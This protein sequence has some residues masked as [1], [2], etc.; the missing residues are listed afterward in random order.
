MYA[1]RQP[2]CRKQYRTGDELDKRAQM[3]LQ[4]MDGRNEVYVYRMAKC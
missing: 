1:I 4:A 2:H 3:V